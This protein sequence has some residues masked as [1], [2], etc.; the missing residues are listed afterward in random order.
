MIYM[1][2]AERTLEKPEGVQ[3]GRPESAETVKRLIARLFNMKNPQNVYLTRSGKE[4]VETALRAFTEPGSHV[5]TTVTEAEDTKAFLKQLEAEGRKLTYI[6]TDPYGRLDYDKLEQALRP[7]TTT[8]VCAHGSGVSGNIADLERICSFARR[9]GLRVIADGRQTAGGF[10]VNLENLGVDVYCFTGEKMLMGPAGIGGICLKEG[11]SPAGLPHPEQTP[12]PEILGG[13][14][15][16]VEFILDRGIYGVAMLP[17]RL[18]KRFFESAKGMDGV[19]IYGDYGTK[20]RLPIVS[21]K[22]EGHTPEEIRDYL[23]GRGIVI[24]VEQGFA[25]FSFGYFNTRPQVKETVW[26]LMDFLGIDDL[27]LLP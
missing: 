18:E 26:A 7:E 4:A 16:A 15:R 27:Y 1:N 13:F 19:T 2:N 9:H 22:A 14:A 21:L 10:D 23:A 6:G 5:M 3:D 25:R 17:H 20:D 11:V 8:V 24:G 12:P